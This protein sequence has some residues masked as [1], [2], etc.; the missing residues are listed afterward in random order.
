MEDN[1]SAFDEFHIK[2]LPGDFC[3][4]VSLSQFVTLQFSRQKLSFLSRA[5]Q[6]HL[7]CG[8]FSI[9]LFMASMMSV[10]QL[11]AELRFMSINKPFVFIK[12]HSQLSPIDFFLYEISPQKQKPNLSVQSAR[13]IKKA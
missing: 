13:L 11:S 10:N 8:T 12:R 4:K 2:L 6:S 9:D 5:L 3:L 1:F 7:R